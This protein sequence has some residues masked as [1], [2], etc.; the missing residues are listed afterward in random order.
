MKTKDEVELDKMVHEYKDKVISHTLPTFE[1]FITTFSLGVTVLLF[2]FPNLMAKDVIAYNVLIYIAPQ[3]IWG[4]L[5]MVTGLLKG[6]GLLVDCNLMRSSGLVF[7]ALLYIIM[8]MA[9]ATDFPSITAILYGCLSGYSIISITQVKE[10]S[11]IP[12]GD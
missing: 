8:S 5:F 9:Y 4:V 10:T 1:L 2:I 11:I 7:S 3:Y 6:I 12:K